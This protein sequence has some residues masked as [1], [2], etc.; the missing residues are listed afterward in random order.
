MKGRISWFK[1]YNVIQL[2]PSIQIIYET[3]EGSLFKFHYLYLDLMWINLGISISII[4][5]D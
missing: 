5:E 1:H 4:K 2:I 3:K